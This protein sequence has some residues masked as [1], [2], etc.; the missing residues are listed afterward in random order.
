MAGLTGPDPD[1]VHPMPGVDQV[2]FLAPLAKGRPNVQ[3][4]PYT[5]YDDPDGAEAFFDRNVLYH[6]EFTGDRLV[7]GP[8]C[9]IARGA[10][11]IMNGATH[12]MGG[13]STY[14]FNIFGGGWEQGFDPA[15][16]AAENRG[17]TVVGADVWIGYDALV[18]PGVTIGP[19]AIVAARSV[20]AS[21]VPPYAIVAGNPARV[22]RT[23][24]DAETVAALLDLAWW[25]WPVEHLSRHLD[26]VR[27]AD[28][29]ALR[30]A[31]P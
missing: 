13:F 9:A 14:P 30:K 29:E 11:F 22:L 2:V 6:Y 10:K 19:G 12:A 3:V 25:D 17:D 18:M 23:R 4:G 21:D 24:F 31:R 26:A 28:L 5:Y 1:T 27:G 16:W 8:F 15:T 7:I 20:V